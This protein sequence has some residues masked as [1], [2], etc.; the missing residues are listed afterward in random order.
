MYPPSQKPPM[1]ALCVRLGAFLGLVYGFSNG[2]L[3]PVSDAMNCNDAGACA[4]EAESVTATDVFLPVAYGL[5][6]GIVLGFLV[7][8]FINW[9]TATR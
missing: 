1:R 9:L 5:L 4:P 8:L 7:W 3:T 6:G 2:V